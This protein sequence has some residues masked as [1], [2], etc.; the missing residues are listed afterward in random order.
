MLQKL[1][2]RIANCLDH[3]AEAERRAAGIVDARLR[4]DHERMAQ[5]WRRLARSY[6]FIETLQSFLL[7]A[8]KARRG[9]TK[10]PMD[11][12]DETAFDSAPLA[13][14]AAAYAKA[15]EVQSGS[16]R[17]VIAKRIV[18]LASAG[19]R[20]PDTLCN[21]AVACCMR[22]PLLHEPEGRITYSV[23]R[24]GE[25][26]HWRVFTQGGVQVGHGATDDCVLSRG[27]AITFASDPAKVK[28]KVKDV[29]Q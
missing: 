16:V 14:V 7:D 4:G 24:D 27:E 22:R 28:D 1:G 29:E 15:V 23:Q 13:A 25:L 21:A 18:E 19:E 3:A 8:E 6:Q 26:W 5:R 11:F 9:Q 10:V 17:A 2:D 20:D 12:L